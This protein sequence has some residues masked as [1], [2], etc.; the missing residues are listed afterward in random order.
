[1]LRYLP[2]HA[3]ESFLQAFAPAVIWSLVARTGPDVP[4]GPEFDWSRSLGCR[5]SRGR[6][7]TRTVSA[8]RGDPGA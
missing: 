2:E 8:Q 3:L 6:G 5:L 7:P 4:N 1:M